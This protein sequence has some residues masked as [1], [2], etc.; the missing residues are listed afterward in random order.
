MAALRKAQEP[1]NISNQRTPAFFSQL[2]YERELNHR[3]QKA[4]YSAHMQTMQARVSF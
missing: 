3:E 4:M 2:K 1:S